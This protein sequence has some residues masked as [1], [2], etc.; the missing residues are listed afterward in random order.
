MSNK[1][2]QSDNAVIDYTTIQ[3]LIDAVNNMQN[4][5]DSIKLNQQQIIPTK[6]NDGTTGT[7]KSGIQQV[8]AGT[9]GLSS[10]TVK[11]TFNKIFSARPTLTCTVSGAGDTYAYIP[12][13]T[14]WSGNNT[15]T[16]KI[17]GTPAGGSLHWI[18]VGIA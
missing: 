8:D 9:I 13:S 12:G 3:S 5:I 14:S 1:V 4:D 18:A 11:I 10:S 2:V 7:V 17:H 15:V 16:V 6:T